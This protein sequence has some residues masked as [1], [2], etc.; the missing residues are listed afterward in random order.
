MS[1]EGMAG[2]ADLVINGA[3][4]V[5]DRAQFSASIA[6]KDGKIWS[7]GDEAGMPASLESLD[8]RGLYVLPGAI[9]VHVHFREPGFT[10]KETWETGTASAAM[11]GV[12]TVF[13][14]PNTK[15]PTGTLPALQ[16]KLQ[17]AKKAYVDFGIYGLL[18]EDN[19][20]QLE[21]LI[22][23]GVAAFKCFMGNT[24]GNLPSPPTGAMLEGF[25]IIAQHGYRISLHA[26]T[27]SIMARRE[28]KLKEAG[29]HDP[30]A[31]LAARPPV[32]AVE[33][34]SR[35]AV[36]AEWTGARIHI[37]H[38]SSAD[39]LRPLRDAKL[40]GVDITAE[41]APHYL[42]FDEKAY[43]DHGSVIRVNP[44]VRELHH[45]EAL[46]RALADRTID[47]IATDHAPHSAAE[48][49][50]DDIWC[51][52]CGFSGVETQMPLMLTQVANGRL[53][54]QDYVR[55]TSTAPA[56]AFGLYPLKG[57]LLPGSDA[58]IVVVDLARQDV[59]RS[60]RL[61]SIGSTTP[62]EATPVTGLPVHTL[63]RGRFV[64]K[65]R[66]LVTESRGHGRSVRRIQNMPPASPRNVE[67]TIAAVTRS[68]PAKSG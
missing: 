26:E 58:D 27:A 61:Q 23:G 9:D 6:I 24:F 48:K 45:Q 16:L 43:S 63:V 8:A 10:H 46:W 28:K 29:R 42:L 30:L 34:V 67:H 52:D 20:D 68:V 64:M 56:Q 22:D 25:E 2:L 4:V 50:A 21:A 18:A 5:T 47:M 37:L 13:E 35:A 33:A 38:V 55:L 39:E 62:F 44:P 3:T 32:V 7:I 14:M 59:V 54:I 49:H 15:P 11:G 40:R 17:A 36:L 31:H 57:A 19:I 66:T 53:S 65:D 41:T 60:E 51:A 12:T 1:S